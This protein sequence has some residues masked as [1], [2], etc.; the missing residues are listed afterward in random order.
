MARKKSRKKWKTTMFD[1]G[2]GR[3]RV[4]T[5]TE[6]TDGPLRFRRQPC[7]ECP[8]RKDAPVGAF[9]ENAYR[10]S[11]V[12]AW[13]MSENL[14]SCHMSGIDNGAVCAG[15]L[16]R[17]AEHNLGIRMAILAGR[18]S[19]GDLPETDVELYESY[20]AMAEANGLEAGDPML[21][22]CR[23]NVRY[24]FDRG[25]YRKPIGTTKE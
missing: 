9:P 16:H 13:D 25:P 1:C 20:R 21:R 10:H 8:W 17:G 2:D 11:A 6:P 3:H 12:T 4:A 23:A 19:W 18:F 24:E 7:A 15:F 14:F 5:V 22:P